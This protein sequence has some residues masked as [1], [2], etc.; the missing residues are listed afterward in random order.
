MQLDFF[1][2]EKCVLRPL[3]H[4]TCTDISEED[5]RSIRHN[6]NQI[7]V[8]KKVMVIGAHDLKGST[9]VIKDT[10]PEGHAFLQMDIFNRPRLEKFSLQELCFM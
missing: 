4:S 1:E 7:F 6:P 3:E 2:D 9:G 5:K 8:G 10:T